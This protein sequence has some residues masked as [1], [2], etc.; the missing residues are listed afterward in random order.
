MEISVLHRKLKEAGAWRQAT[1]KT[2]EGGKGDV[3][4]R[5]CV[6]R[7]DEERTIRTVRK[8]DCRKGNNG[9]YVRVV[10]GCPRLSPQGKKE[11]VS[12]QARILVRAS[13]SPLGRKPFV[14]EQA[15]YGGRLR[16]KKFPRR[17]RETS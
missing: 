5:A 15:V 10:V 11:F 16:G 13:S 14:L 6:R 3:E 17:K 8:K 7:Y 12:S 1:K 4:L 9:R 2:K